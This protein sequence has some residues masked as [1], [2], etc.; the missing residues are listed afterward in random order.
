MTA[1]PGWWA[2]QLNPLGLSQGDLLAPAPIGTARV[3]P[4]YIGKDSWPRG[5]RNYW[6]EYPE[7]QPGK[8]DPS[9][10]FLAK[11]SMANC[12]VISH[13]C[14]LDDKPNVGRVLVAPA[15][16]IEVVPDVGF[17]ERIMAGARRAFMPLP[18]VP[19]RGDMYADLRMIA[20]VERALVPDANRLHSMT[21][22]AVLR[23]QAQI[24][25]FFS[26]LEPADI[27]K[28]QSPG[29]AA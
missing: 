8:N 7:F 21:D 25:G 1:A 13:S 6:P 3:P 16:P 18:G 19:E 24:V 26:R 11:G 27:A 15:R 10:L 28:L 14:E 17:R 12:I 20:Y 2:P 29:P 22:E 4:G 9:G 23:L 5:G